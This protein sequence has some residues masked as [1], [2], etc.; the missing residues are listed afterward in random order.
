MPCGHVEHRPGRDLLLLHDVAKPPPPAGPEAR[1]GRL[2]LVF[3][4]FAGAAPELVGVDVDRCRQPGAGGLGEH[5]G[6]VVKG[7]DPVPAEVAPPGILGLVE[8]ARHAGLFQLVGDVAAEEAHLTPDQGIG[9]GT[10]GL[11]VGRHVEAGA[12][13]AHVVVVDVGLRLPVPVHDLGGVLR[14]DEV[15]E[16][17]IPVVVVPGVRM[18]EP[19]QAHSLVLA[20]ECFVVP[21]GDHDLAIRVEA[22]DQQEDH[23]V[24]NP[25]GLLV[26][27]GEQVVDQLGRHLGAADLGGVEAHR[28]ADHRL[29]LRDQRIDLGLVEPLRVEEPVV[30]FSQLLELGQVLRRRHHDQEERV[31]VGG[32]PHVGDHD[33][34]ALLGEQFVVLDDGVPSG[35]LSI[36][37]QLETEEL[38]GRRDFRRGKLDRRGDEEHGTQ[39][40]RPE[41]FLFHEIL[42]LWNQAVDL[43]FGKQVQ[44]RNRRPLVPKANTR[45]LEHDDLKTPFRMN[46]GDVSSE[47]WSDGRGGLWPAMGLTNR[48]RPHMKKFLLV[49][50]TGRAEQTRSALA[51]NGTWS[52]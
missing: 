50:A 47:A 24:E 39:K 5:P 3:L 26:V 16:V 33:L 31:V 22:G 52:R 41:R 34:V 11:A 44:S 19:R 46:C 15:E 6:H 32:R 21:V 20:P 38:V 30:H 2:G 12:I 43:R 10:H 36:C 37:A 29:A 1:D 42:I 28:L 13:A 18:V 49:L 25:P 4:P 9:V 23:V 45:R 7:R 40:H 48:W 14:L 27:P 8:D 35:D 17:A 51:G